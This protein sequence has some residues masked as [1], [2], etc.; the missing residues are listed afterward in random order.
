MTMKLSTGDVHNLFSALRRINN[1]PSLKLK[2]EVQLAAVINENLLL[3]IVNGYEKTRQKLFMEMRAAGVNEQ[4]IFVKDTPLF[5]AEFS[6]RDIELREAEIELP[7]LRM[8]K[9]DDLRPTKGEHFIPNKIAL[10][11]IIEDWPE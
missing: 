1:D 2:D 7:A 3:P 9:F 4:G 10:K 5:D 8:I 11:P 6:Q